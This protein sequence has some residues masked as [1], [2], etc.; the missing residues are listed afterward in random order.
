MRLP[1]TSAGERRGGDF[2]TMLITNYVTVVK[3]STQIKIQ[4]VIDNKHTNH[5]LRVMFPTR[6]KSDKFTAMLPF[7]MYEWDIG[8][9]DCS[10]TREPD[11][12]VNPNQGA[13]LIRDGGSAFALYTKGLYEVYLS[14]TVDK[15]AYLTLFRAF[16]HETSEP[17]ADMGRMQRVI[18]CEY[19]LDFDRNLDDS[20]AV[21]RANAF[22]AGNIS[23]EL[24]PGKT[25]KLVPDSIFE[26]TG[27][28]VVS[29]LGC[30]TAIDG[31]KFNIIR[32]YDVSG[33]AAGRISFG[34]AVTALY[35][36]K[37]NNKVIK[38]L[39][40]EKGGIEYKL[41]PKEIKTFAFKL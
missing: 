17:G 13:V 26:M 8:K 36:V 34:K 10:R 27:M 1:L 30:G 38:K 29:A 24:Q 4:T 6:V 19:C 21:R 16:P 33:G 35:E 25:G 31:E 12:Q 28:A 5:R 15:S 39:K 23:F 20:L 37:L 41:R 32:I 3:D 11:T 9:A 22:K 2:A 14:D 7:D 40:A 18:K